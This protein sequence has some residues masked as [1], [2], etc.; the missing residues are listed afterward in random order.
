MRNVVLPLFAA[1]ALAG[2][3]HYETPAPAGPAR[4]HDT[5]Y[6][7][8]E[9]LQADIWYSEFSGDISFN[10]SQPAYTA[11]FL[12]RPG[13]GAS[14]VFPRY[15]DGQNFFRGGT[16]RVNSYYTGMSA[17]GWRSSYGSWLDP[18]SLGSFG[19]GYGGLNPVY[20]YGYPYGYSYP[21]GYGYGGYGYGGYGYGG[22][23]YD[24][25]GYRYGYNPWASLTFSQPMYLLLVAST[26]PL[27][28]DQFTAGRRIMSLRFAS[29]NITQTTN[30]ITDDVVL[31]PEYANWTTATYVVWPRAP[32]MPVYAMMYPRY[33]R[34]SVN[35]FG[36]DS[37]TFAAPG[38]WQPGARLPRV[39]GM[40]GDSMGPH[41]PMIAP[42]PGMPVPLM[43]TEPGRVGK[44]DALKPQ[45]PTVPVKP[46]DGSPESPPPMRRPGG[47]APIDAQPRTDVPQVPRKLAPTPPPGRV[48]APD[49]PPEARPT[50]RRPA[51]QRETQPPRAAEPRQ[52]TP[53]A[54]PAPSR[55]A[56]SAKPAPSRPEPPP[57][58]APRRAAPKS[59]PSPRA[60]PRSRPSPRATPRS[61]PTS[62]RPTSRPA[63]RPAPRPSSPP[64]V[65]PPGH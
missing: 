6:G 19:Y 52:S 34:P 37:S 9:P 36:R 64:D 47:H 3:Y 23:G 59:R 7:Q 32:S 55:P 40:P 65:P 30:A 17:Y 48:S 10:V 8:N 5:W 43:P 42:E 41:I 51:N 26:E 39:P 4:A 20:G 2:C 44:P 22:Y 28:T 14:M 49:R 62:S 60:T 53:R 11:V 63:P 45:V 13:S 38:P 33:I 27:R 31:F 21:Y 54:A 29:Y 15:G 61:R 18:W 50:A 35:P 56:P 58:R 24:G 46:V 1:V 16:H 57:A 25:Y 12:I